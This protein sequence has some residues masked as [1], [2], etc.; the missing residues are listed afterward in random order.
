MSL[1]HKKLV[2]AIDI[3][4]ICVL[5]RAGKRQVRYVLFIAEG[6][7]ILI[8]DN[9]CL[10]WKNI[11]TKETKSNFLGKNVSYSSIWSYD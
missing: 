9:K 8:F 7:D 11:A 4:N 5:S 6:K 2:I 3:R 10:L 1:F